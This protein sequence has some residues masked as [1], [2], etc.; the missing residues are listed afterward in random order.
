M[1]FLLLFNKTCLPLHF[2][3]QSTTTEFKTPPVPP[4]SNYRRNA[5]TRALFSLYKLCGHCRQF[6]Q[7]QSVRLRT[8][9][10]NIS[11][12]YPPEKRPSGQSATANSTNHVPY[13]FRRQSVL[14]EAGRDN[15]VKI[16]V[17]SVAKTSSKD[18]PFV[19]GN[20]LSGPTAAPLT[21]WLSV[22]ELAA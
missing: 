2:I 5:H 10:S 9:N 19:Q 18:T 15:L 17:V 8:G 4:A 22:T 16:S 14:G 13:R 7:L 21:D 1:P 6:N 3:S 12:K 11:A 20:V